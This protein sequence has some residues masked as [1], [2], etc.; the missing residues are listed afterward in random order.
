MAEVYSSSV[1]ETHR[2]AEQALRQRR[3]E[4]TE[5]LCGELLRS[6]P[7]DAHAL[8]LLGVAAAERR[9]I[10][11]ALQALQQAVLLEPERA[12]YL[13]Q[14][15]RYLSAAKADK[16]AMQIARAAM[17]LDSSD[18]LVLDTLGCVFSRAGDHETALVNFRQATAIKP[19][20]ADFQ[21]NL[22]ASLKF[23][24][25]LDAAEQAYEAAIAADPSN[26]RAHWALANLRRQSDEVNHVARLQALLE[27]DGNVD[28]RLYLHYALAKEQED[29]GDYASAFENWARANSSKRATLDYDVAQDEALF[30]ALIAKGEAGSTDRAGEPSAEPIFV[31]GMPRTGTTLTERILSSHSQVYS[32]GE[33]ENFGLILKRATGSRSARILD[34]ETIEKAA[35]L[36]WSAIGKQYLDSTRPATGHT[37][38]FIDKTPLNFLLIGFIHRALPNARIVCLRRHPLDTV[39]SNFRQLFALHFSY[40]N[41]AYDLEDCARYYLLFDRLMRHWDE[42]LPGKVLR[43]DYEQ[44]VAYQEAQS[45]RIVAHCGLDWEPECLA[46]EKN[47]APVA[48][49]SAVQVREGLYTRAVARWKRYEQQLEPARRILENAGIEL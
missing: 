20:H 16:Q 19:D 29:L 45:R 12:D 36:D 4:D 30:D 7:R 41:Y 32:A 47:A 23:T 11:K 34:E 22:A 15:A 31:L 5:R 33:L 27:D 39:L 3:F 18:P 9:Q 24:G 10:P 38:H 35:A 49:A 8:F 28:D 17:Q 13:A 37:A 26:A 6:T 40:Y 21:F 44:L 2:A 43:V 48:T 14:F 25:E 42:Q 46:F 1:A